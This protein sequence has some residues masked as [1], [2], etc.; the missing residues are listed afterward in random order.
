[1]GRTAL[2]TDFQVVPYNYSSLCHVIATHIQQPIREIAEK[3]QLKAIHRA[4]CALR[5]PQIK[6]NLQVHPITMIIEMEYVDR[7]H[8]QDYATFEVYSF[9]G[10]E[11]YCLRIHIVLDA[12][13]AGAVA[14]TLTGEQHLEEFTAQLQKDYAA[15]L[16]IRKQP[17]TFLAKVVMRF[18][19]K[20]LKDDFN[21][22]LLRSYRVGLFGLSMEV[23]DS[24]TWAEQD[25]VVSACAASALTVQFHSMGL[26]RYNPR[27]PSP[28]QITQAAHTGTPTAKPIFPN[29]GLTT[30]MMSMAIRELGLEPYHQRLFPQ[31][32]PDASSAETYRLDAPHAINRVMRIVHAYARRKVTAPILGVALFEQTDNQSQPHRAYRYQALHAV[33]LFGGEEWQ[34]ESHDWATDYNTVAQSGARDTIRSV[35]DS[36]N[37]LFGHDDQA[38]PFT[39]CARHKTTE[40]VQTDLPDRTQLT[41]TTISEYLDHVDPKNYS[42]NEAIQTHTNLPDRFRLPNH[43]L[44]AMDHQIRVHLTS[45]EDL[46][47]HITND[48]RLLFKHATKTVQNKNKRLL[49][50]F[51]P[52]P[53]GHEPDQKY[54]TQ[55]NENYFPGYLWNIKLYHVNILKDELRKQFRQADQ[56][57]ADNSASRFLVKSLPL[58]LWRATAWSG[59]NRIMDILID[60]TDARPCNM[61]LQVMVYWPDLHNYAMQ[62]FPAG[63]QSS[64]TPHAS[65]LKDHAI[66]TRWREQIVDQAPTQAPTYNDW[67]GGSYYP[68]QIKPH[69]KKCYYMP[70]SKGPCQE[71]EGVLQLLISP[72]DIPQTTDSDDSKP[73]I[74]IITPRE[75]SKLHLEKTRQRIDTLRWKWSEGTSYLWL[76]DHEGTLVIGQELPIRGSKQT[77]GH[78][79]LTGG[80]PARIAGELKWFDNPKRFSLNN[81]SGR[82]TKRI[83]GRLTEHIKHASELFQLIFDIPAEYQFHKEYGEGEINSPDDLV[84]E[85]NDTCKREGNDQEPSCKELKAAGRNLGMALFWSWEIL[86][87]EGATFLSAAS[88]WTTATRM[89]TE[90]NK[91]QHHLMIWSL[92]TWWKH[93]AEQTPDTKQ[94]IQNFDHKQLIPLLVVRPGQNTSPQ[95]AAKARM[96]KAATALALA[97][98]AKLRDNIDDELIS[99]IRTFMN[100]MLQYRHNQ[101]NLTRAEWEEIHEVILLPPSPPG[102]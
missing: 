31:C 25:R 30:T 76:I 77:L 102:G 68:S 33:T 101:L 73:E 49:T 44:L 98:L 38:G 51:C 42:K 66:L 27:Y 78:P 58:Y 37:Y 89:H 85:L 2:K 8:L 65:F 15:F 100:D 70:K 9:H 18:P 95:E 3:S 52:W 96:I 40:T 24:L 34:P 97:R 10:Y 81:K 4:L 90:T 74:L 14:R 35:A 82:Y 87:E 57:P 62:V 72:S 48:L 13:P 22:S 39:L 19:W 26:D 55:N 1:M 7:S 86:K 60:A 92:S 80:G 88:C 79:N 59:G 41:R 50:I 16:V 5:P 71:C 47:W 54:L 75:Y 69:E 12:Y 36:L 67:Y 91:Q 23:H 53:D 56:Q 17:R 20:H 46:A 6:G 63:I 11:R 61:V 64:R 99:H 45:V 94:S 43:V 93:I 28:A 29:D 83:S 84:R 32:T 21:L